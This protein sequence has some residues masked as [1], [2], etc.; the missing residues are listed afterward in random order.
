L[1]EMHAHYLINYYED[2]CTF[3]NDTLADATNPCRVEDAFVI[4]N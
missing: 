2:Y 4:I 3:L 1:Y